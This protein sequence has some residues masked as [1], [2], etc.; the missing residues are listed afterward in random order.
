MRG[1]NPRRRGLARSLRH[2]PSDAEMMLRR[3]TRNR[4]L[5]GDKFV[6]QMPIGRYYAD[7]ACRESHVVIEVDGS[8]HADS[9]SDKLRDAY[10]Q[11]LG[12]QVVR[13][14]NSEI[15]G[16]LPIALTMIAE[17]LSEAPHPDPLPADAR[18]GSGR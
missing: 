18:R 12:Y 2:H 7:F 4:Q 15:F 5:G 11:A 16:N 1:K 14:W 10:L 3:S 9:Q 13:V 8:Q 17:K 6:R